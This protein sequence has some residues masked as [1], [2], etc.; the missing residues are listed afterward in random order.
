MGKTVQ[1]KS[2]CPSP[3]HWRENALKYQNELKH[4]DEKSEEI[5]KTIGEYKEQ[6]QDLKSEL[7]QYKKEKREIAK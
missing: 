6:Y 7:E 1:K 5:I 4:I 2:A 3:E